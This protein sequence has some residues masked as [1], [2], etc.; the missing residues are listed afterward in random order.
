M[1][2][3]LLPAQPKTPAPDVLVFAEEGYEV[4]ALL[5]IRKLASH[6]FCAEFSPFETFEQSRLYAVKRGIPVVYVV[7]EDLMEVRV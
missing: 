1:A 7:N 4:K 5:E 6:G 3:V 2:K